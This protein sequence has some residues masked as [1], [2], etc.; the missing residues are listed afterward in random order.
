MQMVYSCNSNPAMLTVKNRKLLSEQS[1]TAN[2]PFLMA[3]SI[4]RRRHYSSLL[5]LGLYSTIP[6]HSC[7]TTPPL[8]TREIPHHLQ[9][10]YAHAQHV[11]PLCPSYLSNLVTFCSSD[12]HQRQL[13][14][15]TIRSAIVCHTRTKF[16]RRAFSLRGPDI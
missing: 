16:G 5:I 8:V 1:F 9:S 3:T 2:M 7:S 15:S 11:P 13:R 6:H 4:L 10:C 12:P 14:L